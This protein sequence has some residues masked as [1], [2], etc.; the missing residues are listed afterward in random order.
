MRSFIVGAVLLTAI[1][2]SHAVECPTAEEIKQLSEEMRRVYTAY[3]ILKDSKVPAAQVRVKKLIKRSNE[4]AEVRDG[5]VEC[6]TKRLLEVMD[7]K[8]RLMKELK[9]DPS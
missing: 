7:E 9:N 4:L 5:Y 8:D 2:A 1:P 6:I 3:E